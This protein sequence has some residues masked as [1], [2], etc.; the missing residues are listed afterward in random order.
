MSFHSVY[1]Q[2]YY[3]TIAQQVGKKRPSGIIGAN[4][5]AELL[6][7]FNDEQVV[8]LY[9]LFTETQKPLKEK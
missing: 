5:S 8:Q 2:K 1:L 3:V 9:E 4:L 6:D 7:A